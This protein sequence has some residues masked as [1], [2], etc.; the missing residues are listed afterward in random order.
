MEVTSEEKMLIM[1]LLLNE[2]PPEN[3]GGQFPYSFQRPSLCLPDNVL[4]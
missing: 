4:P 3:T 2:V 1:E